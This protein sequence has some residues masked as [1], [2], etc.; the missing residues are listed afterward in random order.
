MLCTSVFQAED[1]SA[2]PRQDPCTI[3]SHGAPAWAVVTSGH[4]YS[5]NLGPLSWAAGGEPAASQCPG[6]WSPVEA[7]A[8]L[9]WLHLHTSGN[10]AQHTQSQDVDPDSHHSFPSLPTMLPGL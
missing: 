4:V 1:Q 3:G 10:Q 7:G 5:E 8:G 9:A 6:P 2:G